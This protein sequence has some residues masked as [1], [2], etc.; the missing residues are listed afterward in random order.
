[1]ENS[2]EFWIIVAGVLLC[3]GIGAFWKKKKDDKK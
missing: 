2:M 1:M 3:G